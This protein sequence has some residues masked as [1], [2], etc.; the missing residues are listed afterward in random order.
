M[1]MSPMGEANLSFSL[2]S[3]ATD[4]TRYVKILAHK[5]WLARGGHYE[6]DPL[7]LATAKGASSRLRAMLEMGPETISGV[8]KKI[9]DNVAVELPNG[10]RQKSAVA[11][12]SVGG[13]TWGD[14]LAPLQQ[15][16]AAFLAALSPFSA[17][18]RLLNDNAFTRLPMRSRIAIRTDAAIG[19]TVEELQAKPVL[20]MSFSQKQ[21]PVLKAIGQV[22]LADELILLTNDNSAFVSELQKAISVAT[23]VQFLEIVAEGTGVFS[24]PSSGLTAAQI[25]ADLSTALAAIEVGVNTPV[26]FDPA[27]GRVQSGLTAARRWPADCR[28]QDRQRYPYCQRWGNDRW[29]A[30]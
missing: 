3:A 26:L 22:V 18:D 14:E 20:Q 1:A 10:T 8:T 19:S 30:A 21:M 15:A 24:T 29:R 2:D 5:N 17:F 27:G 11:T 25:L 9:M 16:S 12:G 23:D 4:Y 13:T 6:V 28:R 7:Q